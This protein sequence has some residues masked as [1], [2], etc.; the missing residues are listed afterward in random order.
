MGLTPTGKYNKR[1]LQI[2]IINSLLIVLSVTA[3]LF[4]V[5]ARKLQGLNLFIEDYLSFVALVRERVP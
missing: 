4:R 2:V 3:V 1:Q 5:W